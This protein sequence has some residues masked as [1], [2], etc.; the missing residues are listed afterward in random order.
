[1]IL[2]PIGFVSFSVL[3]I[4]LSSWTSRAARSVSYKPNQFVIDYSF[5][6]GIFYLIGFLFTHHT[7]PY[8][9][10]EIIYMTLAGFV[11]ESAFLFLNAA[12]L[13]GKGALAVAIQ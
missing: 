11:L 2:I 7:N 5:I 1:M 10:E 6:A 9:L 13:L 12:L 4:T 3:L 8:K